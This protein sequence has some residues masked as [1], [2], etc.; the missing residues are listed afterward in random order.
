MTEKVT[1]LEFAE[2]MGRKV[3]T[4]R[5][6]HDQSRVNFQRD[7]FRRWLALE[8]VENKRSLEDAYNRGYSEEAV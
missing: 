5:R 4:A 2:R 1:S 8:P 7:Y 3:G 6:E